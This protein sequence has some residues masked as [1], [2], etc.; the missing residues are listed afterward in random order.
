MESLA[1]ILVSYQNN[2]PI[3][4]FVVNLLLAAIL[5]WI[6]GWL[7]M[8]YGTV[9]SNKTISAKNFILIWIGNI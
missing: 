9:L 5:S 4:G 2:I 1:H 6:L 3:L 7:Y 8:K